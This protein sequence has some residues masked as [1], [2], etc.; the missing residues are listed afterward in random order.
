MGES[1]VSLL[2]LGKKSEILVGN[3]IPLEQSSDLTRG[4]R[5]QASGHR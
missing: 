1:E 4:R 5:E 2:T 3:G